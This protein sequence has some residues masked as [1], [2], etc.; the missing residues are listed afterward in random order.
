MDDIKEDTEQEDL[1]ELISLLKLHNLASHPKKIEVL[2]DDKSG[3]VSFLTHES[4]SSFF[5]PMCKFQESMSILF[6]ET[7]NQFIQTPNAIYNI[8]MHMLFRKNEWR[9]S[10]KHLFHSFLVGH[11]LYNGSIQYGFIFEFLVTAWRE[12]EVTVSNSFCNIW[13]SIGNIH[14][15]IHTL[16]YLQSAFV[17]SINN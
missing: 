7:R 6:V 13:L 15:E 10:N 9:H 2:D 8:I 3:W 4:F 12:F 1:S 5:N 11:I 16:K 17:V 14:F